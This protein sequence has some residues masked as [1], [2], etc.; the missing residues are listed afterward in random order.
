MVLYINDENR[1][2]TYVYHTTNH[3]LVQYFDTCKYCE[4]VC[5][6]ECNWNL[7]SKSNYISSAGSI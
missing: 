4:F 2:S 1:V 3:A 6:L 5:V 7:F